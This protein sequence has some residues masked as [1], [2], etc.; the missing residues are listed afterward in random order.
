MYLR[1]SIYPMILTV[2]LILNCSKST[3]VTPNGY[4]NPNRDAGMIIGSVADEKGNPLT[5]VTISLYDNVSV[6]LSVD[7]IAVFEYGLP[8][9][10]RVVLT[11]SNFLGN[12]LRTLVNEV[13]EAGY[14]TVRWAGKDSLGSTVPSGMYLFTLTLDDS[15]YFTKWTLLLRPENHS[16]YIRNKC[17]LYS[18]V[19]TTN[20]FSLEN[21]PLGPITVEESITIENPYIITAKYDGYPKEEKEIILK[22]G[23]VS[24]VH[25]VMKIG[26]GSIS[27][28]FQNIAFALAEED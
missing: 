10:S 5:N 22:A 13:H 25:F 28:G 23:Q 4:Q 12:R 21:I 24:E 7:T 6:P 19:L 9:D 14:Y 20:E 11:V 15:L 26:E 16:D 1:K 2:L 17:P 3:D 8:Q 18:K 27:E